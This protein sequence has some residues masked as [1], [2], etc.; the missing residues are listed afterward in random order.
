MSIYL[1]YP[2]GYYVYAYL[3]ITDSQTARAGTPYY[4]GKGKG[5]RAWAKHPH[6]HTP[7]DPRRIII[8]EQNLSEIGA[9]SIERRLIR[10]W[11]RKDLGTGILHNR[12]DGGEGGTG[13]KPS[14]ATRNK[15][16]KAT[17]LG[18]AKPETKIKNSNKMR[19]LWADPQSRSEKLKQILKVLQS[20]E[21][22]QK[23]SL[24]QK[25]VQNRPEIKQW[26]IETMNDPLVKQE[27]KERSVA[28]W[29]DP[30]YQNKHS[31]GMKQAMKS[32]PNW[33]PIICLDTGKVYD[34]INEAAQD[35]GVSR[36]AIKKS[37]INK[38]STAGGWSFRYLDL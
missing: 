5:N 7:V 3:R 21:Y 2:T 31:E 20:P 15:I 32:K 25:E 34:L 22:S 37:I 27:W 17:K 4:I 38:R 36:H 26:R 30:T 28:L 8:L 11:G 18:L 35:T 24:V 1:Q 12:T 10:W 23:Q 33:K 9:Y 13:V 6:V 29:N 16:S 19:R 14:V